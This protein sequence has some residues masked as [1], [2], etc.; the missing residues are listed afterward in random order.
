MDGVT[1]IERELLEEPR[2]S[3]GHLLNHLQI[4]TSALGV[5]VVSAGRKQVK[6]ARR[7]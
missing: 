1:A 7:G 5:V 6:H 4:K 3:F 2:M